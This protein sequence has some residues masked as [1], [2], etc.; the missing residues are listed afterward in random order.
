MSSGRA[1]FRPEKENGPFH[2]NNPKFNQLVLGCADG[3]VYIV[4]NYELL[5]YAY[6]DYHIQVVKAYRPSFISK[7]EADYILIGGHFP[8][9]LVYQN[10]NLLL[11]ISQE[12]WVFDIC[13]RPEMI[14]TACMNNSM[15][16]LTLEPDD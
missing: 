13:T 5:K 1:L 16:F 10:Q 8:N 11:S 9:L 7:D 3:H 14:A 6:I 12:D 4:D 2:L 15:Y